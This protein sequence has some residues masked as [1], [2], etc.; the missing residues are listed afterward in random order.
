[1]FYASAMTAEGVAALSAD[2]EAVLTLAMDL[3]SSE[4]EAPSDCAGWRV[5]DVIAHLANTF[6]AVADPAAMPPGVPGHL[7][8]SQDAQ[9]AAHRDWTPWEVVADYEAVSAAALDRLDRWQGPPPLM[10]LVHIEDAGYHPLHLVA[11]ALAFDHFCHLRNDILKPL[12]PIHRPAPPADDLRVGATLEWLM[13]GL[14]HMSSSLRSILTEPVVLSLT[15]PGAGSWT[16]VSEDGEIRLGRGM[17]AATTV[18]GR[19]TDFIVWATHRRP[20]TAF[21]LEI[22]GDRM[23]AE[24]VLEAIHLF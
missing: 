19:T 16:M 21:E 18:R 6:R 3:G 5:Q 13:A 12:G 11:N 1:M 10:T 20:W 23:Y 24:A 22:S 14:P 4:W 15:G 8:A 17:W 2:R 7:E 9:A